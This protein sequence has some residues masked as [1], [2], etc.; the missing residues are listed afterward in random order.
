VGKGQQC[1]LDQLIHEFDKCKAPRDRVLFN[2][3]GARI[4]GPIILPKFLFGPLG[5]NGQDKAFFFINYE[6]FRLPA[7]RTRS[8]SLPSPLYEEG[9]FV[10]LYQPGGGKPNEVRTVKLLGPDGLAAANGHV[11]TWDP[12]VKRLYTDIRN[13]TNCSSC[14]IV[15]YPILTSPTSETLYFTNKALSIRKYPTV[16]FDFNLTS[17]HRLEGS[18]N[19]SYLS[20]TVPG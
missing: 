1:T 10:Y 16:R 14:T 9:N 20:A 11:S 3:P 4:G 5:F 17:K 15:R 7:Q 8:R 6:E 19:Y 12:T 2:Q 13:S 18:W